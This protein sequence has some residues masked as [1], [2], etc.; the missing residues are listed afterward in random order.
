MILEVQIPPKRIPLRDP[1]PSRGPS[2]PGLRQIV[3]S[4]SD[5]RY[6]VSY[7]TY[8]L[9]DRSPRYDKTVTAKL[10]FYVKRLKHAVEDK[11]GGDEPIEILSFIRTSKEAADHKD[12]GEGAAA[13]LIPYFLK[14][15][16]KEGF[17]AHMDETT[18]GMLQYPYMY[19]VVQR[20]YL[21]LRIDFTIDR[22]QLGIYWLSSL[23]AVT[24]THTRYL[25]L[26]RSSTDYRI[27]FRWHDCI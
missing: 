24:E 15:A 11:F 20:S 3:R 21:F 1:P 9:D 27:Q 14:D 17:R 2:V 16:S 4:R 26:A 13:R 23:L 10:S 25:N 19:K 6:L 18:S 8:R 22:R 5:Y 12:V 7:R